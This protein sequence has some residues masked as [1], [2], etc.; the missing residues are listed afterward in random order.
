MTIS[1]F[2]VGNFEFCETNN[3]V[4]IIKEDCLCSPATVKDC[5]YCNGAGIYSIKKYPCEMNISNGNFAT[6]WNALGLEHD[7]CGQICPKKIIEV[8][9][10]FDDNLLLRANYVSSNDDGDCNFVS[11][12]ID[13]DRAMSYTSRLK[14]IAMHAISRGVLVC[15]G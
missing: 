11:F 2:P 5:H 3:L 12:G 6:L 14:D 4:E 15:W 1:I 13:K 9:K 8:L 7:Y 10:T